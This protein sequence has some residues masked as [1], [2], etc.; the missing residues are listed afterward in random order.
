MLRFIKPIDFLLSDTT[1]EKLSEALKTHPWLVPGKVLD[2]YDAM[3]DLPKNDI[4]KIKRVKNIEALLEIAK[5]DLEGIIDAI[6]A[7]AVQRKWRL[8]ATKQIVQS[9]RFGFDVAHG[10]KPTSNIISGTKE[11]LN[12]IEKQF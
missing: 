6:N 1:F 5:T 9:L 12:L 4:A 2:K 3:N 8:Q 7:I 10:I 11:T